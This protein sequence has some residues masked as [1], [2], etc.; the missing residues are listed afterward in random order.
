VGICTKLWFVLLPRLISWPLP[1][2][3]PNTTLPLLF[4]RKGFHT[5]RAALLTAS[6]TCLFR[7]YI[8]PANRLDQ[9]YW[10]WFSLSVDTR[11]LY[12]VRRET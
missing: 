4:S 3:H 11:F 7:F 12:A 5:S 2:F 6:L 1:L 8:I 10:D 9:K